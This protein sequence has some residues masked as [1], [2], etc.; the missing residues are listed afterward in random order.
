MLIVQ[1]PES[2]ERCDPQGVAT[3]RS[4]P[5]N[6]SEPHKRMANRVPLAVHG[7]LI[8][9]DK[10][11]TTRITSV[12]TRNVSEHG[13]LVEC[14]GGTAI[15]LYRLVEFHVEREDREQAVLPAALRRTQVLAAVYRVGP[16]STVTGTPH[17]YALRLLVKPLRHRRVAQ[18]PAGGSADSIASTQT[19]TA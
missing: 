11:G 4:E 17:S 12:V 19:L 5:Y 8:W 15:P 13:A 10:N 9:K 14:D 1:A 16:Y 7:R 18:I 3:L 6:R 2:P